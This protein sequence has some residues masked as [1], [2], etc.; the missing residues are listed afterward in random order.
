MIL[1]KIFRIP[2]FYFIEYAQ[3]ILEIQQKIT[4]SA[5]HLIVTIYSSFDEI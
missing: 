2:L 4:K 5:G 3:F 1:V